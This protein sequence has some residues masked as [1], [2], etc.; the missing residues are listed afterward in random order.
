[1]N[2]T[3]KQIGWAEKIKAEWVTGL[4]RL[5]SAATARVANGSMPET[6]LEAT[7]SG[8]NKAMGIINKCDDAGRIIAMHKESDMV[9]RVSKLIIKDWE[10][11]K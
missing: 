8:I 4:N 7:E 11:L 10:A 9:S 2:G 5:L 3:E 1:M 6:W